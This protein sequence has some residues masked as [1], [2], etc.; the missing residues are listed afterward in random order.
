MWFY[1]LGAAVVFGLF[2][3]RL[4]PLP[5]ARL[6]ARPGP[7]EIGHH[8]LKVCFKLVHPITVD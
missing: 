4:A 6:S 5:E 8:D 1:F 7:M 3:I 2:Y